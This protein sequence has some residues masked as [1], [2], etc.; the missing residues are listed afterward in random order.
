MAETL[1]AAPGTQN[2]E[3]GHSP[4]RKSMR[5]VDV[6]GAALGVIVLAPVFVLAGLL[7]L[8]DDGRPIFFRQQRVGK[9]GKLFDILKFRTMRLTASGPAITAAGDRRITRV[10]AHLRKY[11]LDELPQFFSVL[12]GHMNLIG[13]RPEAPEYV[14]PDNHLWQAILRERPGITDLATLAFRNEEEILGPAG[15]PEAYY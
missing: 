2:V 15:D 9:N 5:W 7:I 12:R 13:P 6:G 11:K 14:E 8:L 4:L 3:G 1:S 10:G